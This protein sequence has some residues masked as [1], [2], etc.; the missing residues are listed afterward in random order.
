M[1]VM[2]DVKIVGR[3]VRMSLEEWVKRADER[4]LVPPVNEHDLVY[5]REEPQAASDEPVFVHD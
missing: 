4:T 3:A 5:E 1:R 2:A